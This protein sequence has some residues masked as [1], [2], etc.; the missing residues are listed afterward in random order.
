MSVSPGPQAGLPGWF[1]EGP[2]AEI[3]A[4]LNAGGEEARPIGGA[5]RNHLI[6]QPEGDV[7]IATTAVP[8]EVVRRMQVAGF[9]VVPTGIDHGTVTV[10]AD[11]RG[12]EVTTLREDIETDGRRAVVRFGRDWRADA[13]RRD[14]T[15]NAM[16]LAPDGA[17]VDYF[18]GQAD[19]L[20][21]RIRFIGDPIQRIREDR[22]RIL[23]FFRFHAVYAEGPPDRSAME[24]CIA[25]RLGLSDLSG[26]R[27]RQELLKLLVARRAPGTLQDMADAGILG[28]ILGGIPLCG[29][30]GRLAAI[31]AALGLAAEPA[32]RLAALGVLVR[33]DAERLRGRLKLSNEEFRRLDSVGHGWAAID[34]AQGEMA[35]KIQLHAAGPRS[36][37]DRALVAFARS[38]APPDDSDWQR[39][40]SLPERWHTPAFPIGGADFAAKGLL[41]GPELGA[42]LARAKAA[43]IATGFP[44]DRVSLDA[45]VVAA[46][47]GQFG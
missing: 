36:F 23:R 15:V 3:L 39:L 21:R 24:A 33:E 16:S 6:G 37:R 30:V 25:E 43:W 31:E 22:L 28:A 26:E 46:M 19:L 18:G 17:L 14:F 7:D 34:P 20:A 11:G 4:L 29:G 41:P 9:K 2:A 10:V 27:I 40:V 44:C 45:L 32:R 5:V 12:Y 35:A 8:G 42:A 13:A 38:T 47:P 1:T